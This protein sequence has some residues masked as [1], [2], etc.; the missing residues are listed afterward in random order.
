M[1]RESTLDQAQ[2][3]GRDKQLKVIL[4]C[5]KHWKL[6]EQGQKEKSACNKFVL[7]VA[8]ELRIPLKGPL[9]N[10]I[11]DELS[12]GGRWRLAGHGTRSAK[13]VGLLARSGHFVIAAT[14]AKAG[15]GHVAVVVDWDEAAH[16]PR[17][18]WGRLNKGGKTDE[19]L[20]R[21]WSPTVLT[22]GVYEFTYEEFKNPNNPGIGSSYDNVYF[23]ATDIA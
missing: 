5:E 8:D 13:P 11:F 15:P 10:D 20:T 22:P 12:R 6:Q 4:A 1:A 9:A 19:V 17:A 7:A 18:Y 21:S 23:F 3:A 2:K 14:K 16:R